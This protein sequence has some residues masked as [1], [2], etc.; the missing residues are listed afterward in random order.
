MN[1]EERE[2][3]RQAIDVAQREKIPKTEARLKVAPDVVPDRV[4]RKAQK[5]KIVEPP[6][7]LATQEAPLHPSFARVVAACCPFS[8]LNREELE[9]HVTGILAMIGKT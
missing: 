4:Y 2:L 9:N 6:P 1:A 7:Y 3:L 5:K 8:G